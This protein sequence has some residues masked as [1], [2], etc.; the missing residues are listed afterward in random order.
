[1]AVGGKA[2]IAGSVFFL[3]RLGAFNLTRE[4]RRNVES[5]HGNNAGSGCMGMSQTTPRGEV[6]PH[7]RLLRKQKELRQGGLN[8][9]KH[10]QHATTEEQATSLGAVGH[11]RAA[12]QGAAVTRRKTKHKKSCC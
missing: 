5:G 4:P 9:V 12:P 3:S 1:M 8:N 10:T 7:H 6:N 2:L 11:P